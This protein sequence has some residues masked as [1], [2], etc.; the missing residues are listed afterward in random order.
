MYLLANEYGNVISWK[1]VLK[2][3]RHVPDSELDKRES[4]QAVNKACIYVYT[5]GTTGLPKGI[6]QDITI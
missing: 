6:I 4:N 2:R 5:S 3:G 1:D